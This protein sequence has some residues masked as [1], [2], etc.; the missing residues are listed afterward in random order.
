[1]LYKIQNDPKQVEKYNEDIRRCKKEYKDFD[2]DEIESI[3]DIFRPVS[4]FDELKEY[5]I[6]IGFYI[7]G[8]NERYNFHYA[9]IKEKEYENYIEKFNFIDRLSYRILQQ[10]G[11]K[12][13]Q[14]V[15]ETNTGLSKYGVCDN[16]QQILDNYIKYLKN[17]NKKYIILMAPII[18]EHQPE[19]GGWRWHKCGPYIG[20]QN[21]QH[22]YLCD[23]ENID[24]V[25]VYH[26][27]EIEE[28][29][30]EEYK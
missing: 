11:P 9:N 25:F 21:P 28:I 30:N 1:M 19:K 18:K 17:K 2:M 14:Y 23:E 16:P 29:N 13:R 27:Y 15:K 26:I 4:E 24:M 7:C 3:Y 22:E 12:Y 10:I 5:G 20:T 8:L 6:N